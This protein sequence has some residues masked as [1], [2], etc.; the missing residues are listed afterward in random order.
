MERS[1]PADNRAS[2][3]LAMMVRRA[4]HRCR[5]GDRLEA[6]LGLADTTRPAQAEAPHSLRDR[7]LRPGP[8]RAQGGELGRCPS[9]P[10]P[11]KRGMAPVRAQR[12]AATAPLPR[13][14]LPRAPSAR[15]WHAPQSEPAS[16]TLITSAPRLPR[17]G[18]Q[19]APTATWGQVASFRSH[20]TLKPAAA[21]PLPSRACQR[22]SARAGPARSTPKFRR[23]VTRGSASRPPVPTSRRSPPCAQK[24]GL[25]ERAGQET[26]G[27]R[28]LADPGRPHPPAPIRMPRLPPPGAG[29][30]RT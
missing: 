7:A 24:A 21:R 10:C 18:L 20:S 16:L 22:P 19:L 17:A 26:V 23:A 13:A 12:Q 15:R 14:P 6:G 25:A 29:P 3:F 4:V 27:Q 11:H 28:L 1:P 30:S 9:P 2:Q 5:G 8:H